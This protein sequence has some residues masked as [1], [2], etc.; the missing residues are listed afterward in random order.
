[1]IRK[2]AFA[3]AA[4]SGAAF[5]FPAMTFA[6]GLPDRIVPASCSGP[7]GCTSVCDI[8][9]V[10]QNLLNTGIFVMVF[11]SAVLFAWAGWKM[12]SSQGNSESYNQGKS[13]FGNVVIGLV[14]VLAGWIVV[15]TLM[16]T[17]TNGSL[18]PWN[19]VCRTAVSP[20]EHFYA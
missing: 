8:A 16:K 1:M 13:I 3:L 2:Q 17:M 11:L 18:G 6:A 15:D 19:S 7:G 12:L 9:T 10:A 20:F 14:I 4:S 5:L